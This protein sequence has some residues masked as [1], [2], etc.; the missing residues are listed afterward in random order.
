MRKKKKISRFLIDNKLS[1]TE[2]EKLY[3][4]ES[5]KKICWVV[6]MRIDERFKITA[7]TKKV[8]KL[9]IS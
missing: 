7:G 1:K 8:L 4:I 2:K 9:T 3:V 5:D 6:G